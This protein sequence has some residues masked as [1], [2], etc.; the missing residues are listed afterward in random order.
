MRILIDT[1]VILDVALKRVPYAEASGRVLQAVQDGSISGVVAW[2][3]ISNIYYLIA[4]GRR[5][6]K[7]LEFLRDLSVIVDVAPAN[8][9]TLRLALTYQMRDF[10]D[11]MQAACAVAAGVDAIVTRNV[12]DFSAS[13]VPAIRPEDIRLAQE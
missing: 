9:E 12:R 2:H 8:N 1:D 6:E 3:S 5:R 10:E 13:P 11:A 7:S 4:E